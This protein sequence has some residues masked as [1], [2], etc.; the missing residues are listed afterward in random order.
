MDKGLC[1]RRYIGN[2]AVLMNERLLLNYSRHSCMFTRALIFEKLFL[3]PDAL[4]CL[5]VSE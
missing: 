5:H 4:E 1:I 2:N 3:K